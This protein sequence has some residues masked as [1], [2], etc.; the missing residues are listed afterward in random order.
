MHAA[1]ETGRL[2]RVFDRLVRGRLTA[3]DKPNAAPGVGSG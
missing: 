3:R 2:S 1:Y